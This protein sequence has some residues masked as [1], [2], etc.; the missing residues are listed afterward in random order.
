MRRYNGTSATTHNAHSYLSGS[1]GPFTIWFWYAPTVR[2]VGATPRVIM[3]TGGGSNGWY[4]QHVNDTVQFVAVGYSG[5]NPALTIPWPD[6]GVPHF[7]AVRKGAAGA[8]Q[9]QVWLDDVVAAPLGG[10]VDF[11]LG[12]PS[13]Q[14]LHVGS[15]AGSSNWLLGDAGEVAIWNVRLAGEMVFEG[16]A[17]VAADQFPAGLLGYWPLRGNSSPEPDYSPHKRHFTVVNATAAP[18]IDIVPSVWPAAT[19]QR[20]EPAWLVDLDHPIDGEFRRATRDL[21]EDVDVDVLG[22]P[23]R[24]GIEG[25]PTVRMS[26]PSQSGIPGGVMEPDATSVILHNGD[27]AFD[28]AKEWRRVGVRMRLYDRVSHALLTPFAGLVTDRT[29]ETDAVRFECS[30]IDPALDT[31]VPRV[32]IE[33]NNSVT[34]AEDESERPI[35]LGLPVPIACG[36]GGFCAPP[37]LEH[38]L[39]EAPHPGGRRFALSWGGGV[40]V[41]RAFFEANADHPGLEAAA[42]FSAVTGAT[43]RAANKF[44]VPGIG[45]ALRFTPG[46]L[47]AFSA[48]SGSTWHFSRVDDAEEVSGNTD[49]TLHDAILTGSVSDPLPDLQVADD[50]EL[51][52]GVW[53]YDNGSVVT[54]LTT[55]LDPAEGEWSPVFQVSTPHRA[56]P[57]ALTAFVMSDPDQGVGLSVNAGSLSRAIA[58]YADA[59]LGDAIEA[60]IGGD[61]RQ[62]PA[63]EVIQNAASMRGMVVRRDYASGEYIFE[64]DRLPRLTNLLRLGYGDGVSNL[65]APPTETPT[66][67]HQAVQTL[68]TRYGAGGRIIRGGNFQPTDFAYANLANAQSVGRMV[69]VS[70]PYTRTHAKAAR[71]AYYWAK[72]LERSDLELNFVVGREGWRLRPGKAV[73]AVVDPWAVD[74]PFRVSGMTLSLDRVQC[75]L[76]GPFD[77]DVFSTDP[78]DINAVVAQPTG[79]GDPDARAPDAPSGNMIQNS[80]FS[81]G[82]LGTLGPA[83]AYDSKFVPGWALRGKS[84]SAW[85]TSVDIRREPASIGGHVLRIITD[86]WVAPP[87][88]QHHIFTM[89]DPGDGTAEPYPVRAGQIYV[90]SAHLATDHAEGPEN[91]FWFSVLWIPGFDEPAPPMHIVPGAAP[92]PAGWRR[93][94]GLVRVPDGVTGAV[95]TYNFRYPS[96]EY[97]LDAVAF[98]PLSRLNRLPTPWQRNAAFGLHPAQQRPGNLLV[99]APGETQVGMEIGADRFDE[100]LSGSSV[101][102]CTVQP[103]DVQLVVG[104]VATAI[105][106]ASAW[107]LTLDDIDLYTGMG[108]AA[109]SNITGAHRVF[110]P[111]YP[112]LSAKTLRAVASSGTFSGGR[113]VGAVHRL[114]GVV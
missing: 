65:L 23:Y 5:T 1:P 103:G 11:T 16:A 108:T 100:T 28:R 50:F 34:K 54:P 38:D 101:N 84:G 80:D 40:G 69:T 90:I 97:E 66:P 112:L 89:S 30:A 72:T 78:A 49:V 111:P 68:R 85:F 91:A 94:Y 6:A 110:S 70:L 82:T 62:V 113:V 71:V 87:G 88:G 76:A 92:H 83:G 61:Q 43:Y 93:Y 73:Q 114:S 109:L 22:A 41:K 48:D 57:A 9:W 33:L 95:P 13:D 20:F 58:A 8:S 4:F 99:R 26:L 21:Y 36:D 12:T 64:V 86:S 35:G 107:K 32:L 60:V 2:N 46:W 98:E 79:Q 102:L 31:S 106:G 39:G 96:T 63:R 47:V 59:G 104:Y 45:A 77:A 51:E 52:D 19:K 29:F 7:V 55:V 27:A 56:N 53:E 105:T 24:A 17:G 14:R 74:A 81:S 3:R 42:F 37:Y 75:D 18:H 67:L 10:S 25:E 15:S 44:R